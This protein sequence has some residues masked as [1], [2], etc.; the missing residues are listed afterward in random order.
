MIYLVKIVS[1]GIQKMTRFVVL[2][3]QDKYER[4]KHEKQSHSVLT[5]FIREEVENKAVDKCFVNVHR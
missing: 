3:R 5:M 1:I 4:K 2:F